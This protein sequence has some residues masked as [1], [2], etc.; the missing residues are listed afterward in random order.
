[1]KKKHCAMP[2]GLLPSL[3]KGN[4]IMEILFKDASML[5][6]VLVIALYSLVLVI[7]RLWFH[8]LDLKNR[9]NDKK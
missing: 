5:F 9:V 8:F 4:V 2:C 3:A 7:S 6:V 1:M